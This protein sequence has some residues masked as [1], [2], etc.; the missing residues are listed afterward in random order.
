MGDQHFSFRWGVPVLDAGYTTIPN[1][2]LR[3]WHK[4]PINGNEFLVILHLASYHYESERG[5][6]RPGVNTV[7]NEC[8]ISERQMQR[9]LATLEE[10]G[11]LARRFRKGD[12]TVYDVSG[13][14]SLCLQEAAQGGDVDVTPEKPRYDM[15]DAQPLSE[16]TPKE[17]KEER[18]SHG[19]QLW[20]AILPELRM[21]MTRATFDAWLAGARVIQADNGTI[22]VQA[23]DEYAQ[24]WL[25]GRWGDKI[26]ELVSSHAK[27]PVSVVF[28]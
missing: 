23:R 8:K 22:T 11:M 3:N 18:S 13:F 27:R 5:E 12:T 15:Y 21:Q 1:A 20:S 10:K 4:T 9:R 7:A 17:E 26:N 24:Q 25:S 19:D 14:S 28:V 6:A 16:M 2:I